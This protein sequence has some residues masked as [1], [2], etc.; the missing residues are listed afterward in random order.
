VIIRQVVLENYRPELYVECA[1]GGDP[2][3]LEETL[4]KAI[5]GLLVTWPG[6]SAEKNGDEWHIVIPD[7]YRIGHEAHFAQVT[8]KYLKYLT[9]GKLPDWEVPNMIAKYYTT[10]AA[11][12]LSHKKE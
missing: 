1:K 6:L 5:E 8:E 3:V 11:Y 2:A 9:E 4:N 7:K 10:T 12:E